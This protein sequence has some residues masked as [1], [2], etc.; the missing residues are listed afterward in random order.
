MYT[1]L[2]YWAFLFEVFRDLILKEEGTSQLW[3]SIETSK[4]ELETRVDERTSDLKQKIEE[5]EKWQKQTVGRELRMVDLKAEIKEL[6]EKL[7]KHESS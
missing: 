6:K 1:S 3:R 4:E 7:S 5:L 2:I